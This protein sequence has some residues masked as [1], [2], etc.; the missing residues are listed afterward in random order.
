VGLPVALV[1]RM[2][3]QIS[4]QFPI[5]GSLRAKESQVF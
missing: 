3:H 4:S 5:P 1:F 2:L